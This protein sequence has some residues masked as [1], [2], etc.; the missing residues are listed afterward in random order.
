MLT[1][2]VKIE[3]YSDVNDI[4][5]YTENEVKDI[6]IDRKHIVNIIQLLKKNQVLPEHLKDIIEDFI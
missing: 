4:N 2:G 5:I 6:T 3:T 1:Y